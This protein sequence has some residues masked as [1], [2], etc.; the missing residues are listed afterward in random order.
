M[1]SNIDKKLMKEDFISYKQTLLLCQ[2]DKIY[3]NNYL[4]KLFSHHF[5]NYKELIIE[6]PLL[7]IMTFYPLPNEFNIN[8]L[9]KP[10]T[11]VRKKDYYFL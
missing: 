2:S 9:G 4:Q 1:S 3:A 5:P 7:S 6:N 8:I 10:D 11:V